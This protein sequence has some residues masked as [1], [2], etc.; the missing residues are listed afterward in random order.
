MKIKMSD[1]ILKL[2]TVFSYYHKNC[3]L[4]NLRTSFGLLFRF[5]CFFKFVDT[6]ALFLFIMTTIDVAIIIL[7][8][9]SRL[10]QTREKL[11]SSGISIIIDLGTFKDVSSA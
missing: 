1:D 5:Y 8:T 6:S 9:M 2:N 4:Y 10:S 7:T 3:I 11:R